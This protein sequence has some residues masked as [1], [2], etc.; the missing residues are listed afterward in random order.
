MRLGSKELEDVSEL[1]YLGCFVSA[2]GDLEAELKQRLGRG[3]KI[4]GRVSWFL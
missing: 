1:K 4:C 3:R 2:Y